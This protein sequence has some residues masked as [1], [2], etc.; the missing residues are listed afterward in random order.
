M[1]KK[2][3]NL[4]N[5]YITARLNNST[6]NY[7]KGVNDANKMQKLVEVQVMLYKKGLDYAYVVAYPLDGKSVLAV[8]KK[9]GDDWQEKGLFPELFVKETA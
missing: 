5:G 3:L 1:T 8:N 2:I 7:C 6:L 4:K 9:F